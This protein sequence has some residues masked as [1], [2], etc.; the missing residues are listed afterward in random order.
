MYSNLL[1]IVCRYLVV[2]S[3]IS[4]SESSER[5]KEVTVTLMDELGRQNSFETDEEESKR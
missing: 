3:P 1:Q 5:E 2:T 4:A